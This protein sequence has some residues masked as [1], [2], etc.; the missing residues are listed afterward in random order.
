MDGSDI[1][2]L[3]VGEIDSGVSFGVE[4]GTSATWRIRNEKDWSGINP[5][6]K[7]SITTQWSTGESWITDR[8]G[9]E[10]IRVYAN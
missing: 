5:G 3:S 1:L 6:D 4:K 10:Q 2:L 9:N 8:K 7:L